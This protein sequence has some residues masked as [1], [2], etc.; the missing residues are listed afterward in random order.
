MGGVG[1]TTHATVLYDRIS[2][3]FDARCFILS[4][5]KIYMDGGIIAI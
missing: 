1:K 4:T 5:S 2:Y 3:Q